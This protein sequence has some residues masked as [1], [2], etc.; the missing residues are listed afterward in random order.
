MAT[1]SL[2]TAGRIL[3]ILINPF[4][5]VRPTAVTFYL[6]GLFSRARRNGVILSPHGGQLLAFFSARLYSM[7]FFAEAPPP[8]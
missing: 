2:E 7:V 5:S 4:M 6:P 1:R 8:S 3:T